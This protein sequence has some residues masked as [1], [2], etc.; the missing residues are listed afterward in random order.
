MFARRFFI[1]FVLN[2][3]YY[4]TT[5]GQLNFFKF[6]IEHQIHEYL[7]NNLQKIQQHMHFCVDASLKNQGTKNA[8]EHKKE[9]RL[10]K[11]IQL[12]LW[13]VKN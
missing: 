11:K 8:K 10:L 9:R 12:R 2:N 7:V 6:Y 13:F 4:I 1:L 3:K 5:I